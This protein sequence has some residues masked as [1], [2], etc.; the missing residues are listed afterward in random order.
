MNE[1]NAN[2]LNFIDNI[3]DDQFDDKSSCSRQNKDK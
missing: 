2:F 3:N 1:S